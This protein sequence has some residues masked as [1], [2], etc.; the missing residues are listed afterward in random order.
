MIQEQLAEIEMRIPKL[1]QQIKEANQKLEEVSER[2]STLSDIAALQTFDQDVLLKV[3]E[4]VYVYGPDKVELVWRSD[5][6]F[7]C[8]GL[9]GKREVINPAELNTADKKQ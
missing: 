4:K 2:E 3:L 5:D 6:I 9:M 7:F 1:E 8:E